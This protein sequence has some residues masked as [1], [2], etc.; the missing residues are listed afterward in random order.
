MLYPLNALIGINLMFGNSLSGTD[1]TNFM[2]INFLSSSNTNKKNTVI[3]IIS[4]VWQ[5]LEFE[6]MII[7]D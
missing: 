2:P 4:V 1:L 6:G 3:S 5:S 7:K